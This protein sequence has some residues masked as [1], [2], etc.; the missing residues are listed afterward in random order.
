MDIMSV[1]IGAVGVGIAWFIYLAATRGLPAAWAWLKAR[2]TAGKAEMVALR[3]DLDQLEQG[4]VAEVKSRLDAIEADV[5][6]LKKVTDR[7]APAGPA[8]APPT[9]PLA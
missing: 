7:L 3:A 6:A 4:A 2:W 1:A 8:P 5:G 9:A